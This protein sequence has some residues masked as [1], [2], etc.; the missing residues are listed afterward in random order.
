M[1]N[2]LPV[3]NFAKRFGGDGSQRFIN[4]ILD[5]VAGEARRQETARVRGPRNSG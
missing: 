2:R 1:R 3:A 5:R 4:G